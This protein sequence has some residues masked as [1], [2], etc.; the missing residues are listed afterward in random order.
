[1]EMFHVILFLG[2]LLPSL[3]SPFLTILLLFLPF[4]ASLILPT[5]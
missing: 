3:Y 4:S 5:V 1:M 2:L